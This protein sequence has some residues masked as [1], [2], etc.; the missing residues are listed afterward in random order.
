MHSFKR[1]HSP[2]FSCFELLDTCKFKEFWTTFKQLEGNADL[3]ALAKPEKMRQGIIDVLA[4][5]YRAAPLD[6]VKVALNVEKVDASFAKIESVSATEVLFE[7][8][9]DNTKRDRVFQEGVKFSQISSFVV[10]SQ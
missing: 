1:T 2:L 9:A 8:T 7:A 10:A 5:S 4:L 3:K 6:V